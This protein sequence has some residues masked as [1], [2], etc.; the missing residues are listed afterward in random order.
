MATG[1]AAPAHAVDR[2]GLLRRLDQGLSGPLTLIIA[3]AGAGKSVLLAQWAASQVKVE[4]VWLELT[5]FDD[6]PVR[7]SRRLLAGLS[8]IHPEFGE[9]SELVPLHGAGIG[10]PL[11]EA[12]VAQMAE[13]PEVV[14]VIDDL[15]Q[16]T[17][18]T[19]IS[20]LGRLVDLMPPQIHLV[21][22]SRVDPP[23]AWSRYRL[24]RHLTE[25]RQDEMAFDHLESS[26]LLERILGWP[27][28]P[29]A[30]SALVNRTEGW[31]AGL[32]LAAMTLRSH[33][34]ADT[35]VSHFSGGDRLVADYLSEEVLQVQTAERRSFLLQSSVLDEMT[36]DLLSHL[37]G[38]PNAQLILEELE[39]ESMFLIPL[40]GHREWFRFHHLF[41]DLLRYRL[42]A[43][44]PGTEEALLISAASWHLERDQVTPGVEYL[45]KAREWGQALQV[46]V[47]RG[48][49]VF[50]QGTVK[51]V[52]RWIR[53]VP[54]AA[55]VTRRDVSLLLGA[56]KVADGD[57]AEADDILRRV[58]THPG[59]THGE[60]V[61]A[62]ALLAMMAQWRPNPEVTMQMATTTLDLLATL[63]DAPVPDV[64]GL[65]DP[66]S[67]ETIARVSG[68][69]GSFLAGNIEVARSWLE[70]ALITPG[71][72]YSIWKIHILGSLGLLE[73]WTGHT[74]RAQALADEALD[75]ARA[76][77]VLNHPSTSDAYLAATLVS[78]ERGEPHQAALSLHEATVRAEA[79]DRSNLRWLTLFALAALKMADGQPDDAI[80]TISSGQH[81]IGTPPPPVVADRL[82][83]LHG[84]ILWETGAP[85]QA[86][87][88]L[89]GVRSRS[90]SVNIEVARSALAAGNNDLAR[91]TLEELPPPTEQDEPLVRV[92]RLITLACVADSEGHVDDA[93]ADFSRAVVL[94]E[95]HS[96]VEVF[97]R[98]G[99]A[100]VTLLADLP[101]VSTGFREVLQKRML[102]AASPVLRTELADPLTDR[103][104][105]VLSYLP[106]RYTNSE[107]AE[108][109]FV[110][111]NTIKTHM[112]HIYR[113]LDVANRNQAIARAREIGLL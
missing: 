9:L 39:R 1:I 64:M 65:A 8:E 84:R 83:A 38:E 79:N 87:G 22:S 11:L 86:L 70:R 113:K 10:V 103:E 40:D 43:E 108:R 28:R 7:F 31:V 29:D 51:T 54:L 107:L 53:Q 56:L 96:L 98:A 42:R 48:S 88:L 99:Q 58:A 94:A 75:V 41:R 68:G 60:R 93:R 76:V 111:V 105:E 89:D 97:V 6:D 101:G 35:F 71:S 67:L 112:A 47:S 100:S 46:I 50:E 61:V 23:L 5:A 63:G 110:S 74:Q 27:M 95:Q 12:L 81:S 33:P 109:C 69:R 25:I 73:A 52:V 57:V 21:L 78:L 24:H 14:I 102:V 2:P 15:H 77:G 44:S 37:T 62:Q 85:D 92:E 32:Q 82:L 34:D 55:R 72:A 26:E 45:L 3:P 90:H 4:F 106:S 16:L 19:L 30:V 13:L 80:A 59:S 18:A 36:A 20:D 66:Q 91:K 17:N 104:L 49:E